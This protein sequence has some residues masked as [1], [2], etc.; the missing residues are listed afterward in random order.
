MPWTWIQGKNLLF[1]F[2]I[3]LEECFLQSHHTL[4]HHICCPM[5]LREVEGMQILH[6]LQKNFHDSYLSGIESHLPFLSLAPLHCIPC[7][8]WHTPWHIHLMPTCTL[9]VQSLTISFTE[10]MFWIPL[11][12]WEGS[13]PLCQ[14]CCS[15]DLLLK[16]QECRSD[17][18]LSLV[19]IFF[20]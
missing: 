3:C 7:C 10:S 5:Q 20:V 2:R 13:V 9:M 14:L 11:V 8:W 6:I 15:T 12:L 16:Y 4:F 1:K 17:I 18:S 19:Q